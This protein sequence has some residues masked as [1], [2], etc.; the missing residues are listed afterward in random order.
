LSDCTTQR[1]SQANDIQLIASSNHIRAKSAKS[2]SQTILI[3]GQTGFLGK[4]LGLA[5]RAD[6]R[7]ILTGPNQ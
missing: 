5:C 6:N 3:T 4:S 1:L 7:V 2:M